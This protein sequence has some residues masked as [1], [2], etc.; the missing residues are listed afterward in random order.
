MSA[1]GPGAVRRRAHRTRRRLTN[2]RHVWTRTDWERVRGY[3]A[4]STGSRRLPLGRLLRLQWR[5]GASPDDAL[6]LGLLNEPDCVVAR[7]VTRSRRHEFTMTTS[8]PGAWRD[9]GDKQRFATLFH[10]L[11]GR[12]VMLAADAARALEGD[13]DALGEEIVVKPRW[14]ANGAGQIYMPASDLVGWLA[15]LDP[16]QSEGWVVEGVLNPHPEL[17]RLLPGVLHTLRIVTFLDGEDVEVWPAVLRVGAGGHDSLGRALRID[18]SS[19]GGIVVAV[20]EDGRLAGSGR[21]RDPGT[22]PLDR[23]PR[24]G[25]RFADVTVP[26]LPEANELVKRAASRIPEV[27]S[28]GWDV[29]VLEDGPVIVEGNH[30]W[31]IFVLELTSPQGGGWNDRL[32]RHVPDLVYGGP[33]R[34]CPPPH[35]G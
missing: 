18:S 3:H 6:V 32:T 13:D 30:N 9:L 26:H 33:C 2:L 28:V 8:D 7:R 35:R 10:D 19:V 16:G 1:R 24:S 20:G 22:P 25:V 34:H 17:A 21:V 14:G 11:L 5:H 29:A 15:E 4:S 27:R 31:G 12:R 23:H